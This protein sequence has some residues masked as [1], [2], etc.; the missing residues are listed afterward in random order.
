MPRALELQRHHKVPVPEC[1]WSLVW[2]SYLGMHLPYL[3]TKSHQGNG[4]AWWWGGDKTRLPHTDSWT[5]VVLRL[6]GLY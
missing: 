1:L 4:P 2:V 3:L 5:S 6:H